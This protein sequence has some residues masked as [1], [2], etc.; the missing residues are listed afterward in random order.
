MPTTAPTARAS[1]PFCTPRSW[2]RERPATRSSASATAI[3]KVAAS[4]RS[5]GALPK[6]WAT[7]AALGSSTA[8]GRAGL[9]QAGHAL[10]RR[11]LLHVRQRRI[12]RGALGEGGALAPALAFLG[13]DP[14][15]QQRPH[16]V[17]ARG[18]ADGLAEREVDPDELDAGELH[19]GG[20]PT[21]PP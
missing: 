2:A 20:A 6:S 9:D 7:S 1:K 12:D 21:P 16:A 18:G 14:D 10:L 13:D 15:E 17:H 5:T 11:G 19:G 4:I 8:P 3:S